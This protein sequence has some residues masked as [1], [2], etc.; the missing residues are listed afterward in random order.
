MLNFGV[1]TIQSSINFKVQDVLLFLILVRFYF[2][3]TRFNCIC[4]NRLP[5]LCI[6][7]LKLKPSLITLWFFHF[8]FSFYP[9][10]I[11]LFYL[12]LCFFMLFLLISLCSFPINI[13]S[14]KEKI[15]E[16]RLVRKLYAISFH[17]VMQSREI[18]KG[19]TKMLDFLYT[20][21]LIIQK[22]SAAEWRIVT[23]LYSSS[24]LTEPI[25]EN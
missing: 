2:P 19:R 23:P 8:S 24:L 17:L 21:N 4:C 10:L 13:T 6:E 9:H 14:Y 20:T 18:V 5:N 15:K 1:L 7:N 3:T 22:L 12:Q 16:M 25:V 11:L